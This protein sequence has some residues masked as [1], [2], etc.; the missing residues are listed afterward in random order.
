MYAS[1]N[2]GFLTENKIKSSHFS[3]LRALFHR[4][5]KLLKELLPFQYAPSREVY[6]PIQIVLTRSQFLLILL[7]SDHLLLSIYLQDLVSRY[8]LPDLVK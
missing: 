7:Q 8:A 2:E 5:R 1:Y 3:L 4:N 6:D